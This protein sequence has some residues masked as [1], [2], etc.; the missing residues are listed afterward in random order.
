M[1]RM[2]PVRATAS[3]IL[4]SRPKASQPV[5]IKVMPKKNKADE[6]IMVAKP[7]Y[8]TFLKKSSSDPGRVT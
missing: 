1:M 2:R 3:P 7:S 5:Y 6:I 8:L 4:G